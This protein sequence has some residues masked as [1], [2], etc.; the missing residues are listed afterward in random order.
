MEICKW[1]C[2]GGFVLFL[3]AFVVTNLNDGEK[4][5]RSVQ[6]AQITPK[7]ATESTFNLQ[8]SLNAQDS[9]GIRAEVIQ[10]VLDPCYLTIARRQ[11]SLAKIP[12]EELLILGKSSTPQSFE[13]MIQTIVPVIKDLDADSKKNMFSLCYQTCVNSTDAF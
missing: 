4:G 3:F 2:A 5:K 9:H 11:P 8:D 10:N 1:I 12:A 13:N 7:T 6:K